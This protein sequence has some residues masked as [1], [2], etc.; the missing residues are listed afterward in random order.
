MLKFGIYIA[1]YCGDANLAYFLCATSM[2]KIVAVLFLFLAQTLVERH[3]L[4]NQSIVRY[5]NLLL[6]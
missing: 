5:R 3:G 2:A 4:R 6:L 1:L